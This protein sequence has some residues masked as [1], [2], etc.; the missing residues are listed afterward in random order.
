MTQS[1]RK[2]PFGRLRRHL[3][4]IL[5]AMT[6]LALGAG[7]FFVFPPNETQSVVVIESTPSVKGEDIESDAK[8]PGFVLSDIEGIAQDVEQWDGKLLVINF[9]A[10]WCA[11]C[12]HEIPYFVELQGLFGERG[13]QFVGIAIDDPASINEFAGEVGLNYP[14]L[15]GQLDAMEVSKQYGNT[16]GGLPFTVVVDREGLIVA[17]KNGPFEREEIENLIMEFL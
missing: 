10:T 11:P 17:R 1:H 3:V 14:S 4:I 6:G 13:L 7:V 2:K 12:R 16:V 15:Y 5:A 8:R 9:W